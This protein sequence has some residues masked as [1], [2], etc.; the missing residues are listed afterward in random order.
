MCVCVC[1]C[2]RAR[3]VM[4]RWIEVCACMLVRLHFACLCVCVSHT[5]ELQWWERAKLQHM[6]G[7]C[8]Y[9]VVCV[10]VCVHNSVT[11][12]VC[13]TRNLPL[14][15]F[16]SSASIMCPG[17]RSTVSSSSSNCLTYA[18]VHANTRVHAH[19]ST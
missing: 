12:C 4:Y 7:V 13:L 2:V 6:P 9:R 17:G 14:H 8:V 5:Q 18:H 19:I 1:V 10:Y 15:T 11:Y 3:L 16:T